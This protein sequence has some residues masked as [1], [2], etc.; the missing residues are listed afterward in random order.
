MTR[1]ILGKTVKTI[2]LDAFHFVGMRNGSGGSGSYLLSLIE[3]LSNHADVHLIASPGNVKAFDDLKRRVKRLEVLSAVPSHPDAIR[4]ATRSADILY[5]PF[6]NLP[7]R[8]TYGHV[9]TVTAIHDLQH[10]ICKNF[11]PKAERIDRDNAYFEAV[12]RAD[13]IATFSDAERDN[14]AQFY[15][16]RNNI[17]V[18]PHAPFLVEEIERDY[19]PLEIAHERNPYVARFGR[20]IVYPAVDWPHKNHYRLIEA[21]HLLRTVY[22][23]ADVKLILAGAHCVED[24][25]HFEREL[26]ER[27]VMRDAIVHLGFLT[28]I[29]LF[30]LISGAAAL[31]FPSL[32]EGF[33]IPVLEALRAGTPAIA[34]G[35]PVMKQ[36]FDGCFHPLRNARDSMVM[37]DDIYELLANAELQAVLRE[38]GLKRSVAFSGKGTGEKTFQFLSSVAERFGRTGYRR[39]RCH[40]SLAPLQRSTC[41]LLVHVLVETVSPDVI[42]GI[43]SATDVIRKAI[44]NYDIRFVFFV[45]YNLLSSNNEQLAALRCEA[46]SVAYYDGSGDDSARLKATQFFSATQVDADFHWFLKSPELIHL[47]TKPA[48][49]ARFS[50]YAFRTENADSDVYY[51][52]SGAWSDAREHLVE[53]LHRAPE[54][55]D[56]NESDYPGVRDFILTNEFFR[57]SE[58][59]LFARATALDLA[60]HA[61]VAL[62]RARFA[63]VETELRRHVGHHFSLV[64][65]ICNL[66]ATG[67]FEPIIGANRECDI[68]EA[69]GDVEIDLAFSSYSQAPEEYVTPT[70]F[71]DELLAF[72]NA[73]QLGAQDY[74]YLHMPYSTLLVGILQ[75]LATCSVDELP[76]FIVRICSTDE[77]FRWHDIRETSFLRTLLQF[78]ESRRSRVSIFVESVNLQKYFEQECGV[79][80]P[81]L[82][83]P[84]GR[85]LAA[86]AIERRAKAKVEKAGRPYTFGYFGEAREEK[87]F[88][89]LPEIVARL[90]R[91]FPDHKVAFRIQVSTSPTNNTQAISEAREWLER[92]AESGKSIVDIELFSEMNDMRAYY[93][94]LSGCDAILMPYDP[95][96]YA[97]RGSGVALEALAMDIPVIVP[98][99]TDISATFEGPA[100]L[101]ASA[102][103]AEALASAC[104]SAVEQRAALSESVRRYRAGTRLI[105]S[106]KEF[107][108]ALTEPA[109]KALETPK[110]EKPIA[111]WIGNDVLSQGCSAVYDSQRDF[112]RRHGFEVYNVYVPFPDL[113]GHLSSDEALEKHLVG[114]AL[115]WNSKGFDFGC[116]SWFLNQAPYEGRQNLLDEIAER[117]G[118]TKRFLELNSNNVCPESLLRLVETR[119][120]S[121]VCLN[122]VHL[123]PV[124]E[125]L[126]LIG[127]RGVRVILE[128]HDIQAYQHA[129]RAGREVDD[130]DKI[131]EI[132]RLAEADAVVAINRAER[133]EMLEYE[134]RLNVTHVLPVVR[135]D[136]RLA[137]D[138]RPGASLLNPIWLDVWCSRPDLQ[139]KFDLRSP[140]SLRLFAGW[141]LTFGRSEMPGLITTGPEEQTLA[142]SANPSFPSGKNAPALPNS[143]GWLWELHDDVRRNFPSANDPNHTDRKRFHSWALSSGVKN[144]GLL[145]DGSLPVTTDSIFSLSN[146]SA[147][148]VEGL[149][150][151]QPLQLRDS[152]FRTRMFDWVRERGS[153][154][155]LIVGSDHPANVISIRTFIHET[156]VPYLMPAQ[157]NLLLVGRSA[158]ALQPGDMVQGFFALGE[159]ESL[160][161]LY[162]TATV[163]VVPTVVGTGTPIKALDGLARG[164]CLSLPKFVDRALGLSEFGFPSANNPNEFGRDILELLRSEDA[165]RARRSLAKKYAEN[166]LSRETYDAKW[167]SMANVKLSPVEVAPNDVGVTER[168]G[169]ALPKQAANGGE[170]K[171]ADARL[172]RQKPR[173]RG[174]RAR[175]A[176]KVVGQTSDRNVATRP[177]R[178]GTKI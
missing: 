177:A 16:V 90:L 144:V 147:A 11:F 54:K 119:S 43:A 35:L 45:P 31:A 5:A 120:V 137:R 171:E 18:I 77:S 84:V 174:P 91:R 55:I 130:E 20:Y 36:W 152:E 154:D 40:R 155:L 150:L 114:N 117:D 76:H 29:Q 100:C 122:Y 106:E 10:R 93:S 66:V 92:L 139:Q 26:L 107:L 72:I 49:I 159:V 115:G 42:R 109:L 52:G 39:N 14:I 153:I 81:V 44:P 149:V 99:G 148:L 164:L 51:V 47:A 4:A 135:V 9:P 12:S 104:A 89:L 22:G 71:A 82:L 63:Y 160:E 125:K 145:P 133:D 128:T 74:V 85:D 37:A 170:T 30:Q 83:N 24:R 78:S 113:R 56:A 140:E 69:L 132:T 156:F 48:E 64:Y 41:D 103:T 65:G 86:A 127:R 112:L 102:W 134:P 98:P 17:G 2:A 75:L 28:N 95:R 176:I 70:H 178:S 15:G 111:I 138:W 57:K 97:I 168:N 124:A 141:V 116:Y 167:R 175:G 87:G 96:A 123:L 32:Y 1:S 136:E 79:L 3:H 172:N 46:N 94:A 53:H 58:T 25:I 157:A 88:H 105:Q 23:M 67:G 50:Q 101:V 146:P 80:L 8:E 110:S 19:G 161:P 158:A 33:G 6:T 162:Q 169:G 13:G 60:L 108:D 73:R 131:L 173:D 151:A 121:L 143:I 61:R 126:G 34:T 118:S 166:F 59:D 21:F 142:A 27:K 129:I 38:K 68:M 163:V 7:E 165:R 62:P